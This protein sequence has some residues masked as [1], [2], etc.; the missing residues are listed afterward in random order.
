VCV[1]LLLVLLGLSA[2]P[3][4]S[5]C[6]FRGGEAEPCG[7]ELSRQEKRLW[8]KGWG[9]ENEREWNTLFVEVHFLV[10]L[11]INSINGQIKLKPPNLFFFNHS[12][13]VCELVSQCLFFSNNH[14]HIFVL[15]DVFH[16]LFALRLKWAIFCCC[17]FTISYKDYT[18]VKWMK[19]LTCGSFVLPLKTFQKKKCTWLYR[20]FTCLVVSSKSN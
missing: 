13:F 18:H 5:I 7:A 12:I 20:M 2:Q 15:H 9:T 6:A 10:Q 11:Y 19:T 1:S 8:K 3:C 16:P 14:S 4:Q 17:A